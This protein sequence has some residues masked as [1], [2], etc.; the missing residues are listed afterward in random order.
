V[1]VGVDFGAC[2]LLAKDKIKK[3]KMDKTRMF[4]RV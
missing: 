1:L 2:A 3:Q 4:S